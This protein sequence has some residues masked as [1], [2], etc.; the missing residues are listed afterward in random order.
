LEISAPHSSYQWPQQWTPAQRQDAFLQ[1]PI[2][3]QPQLGTTNAT[4][5]SINNSK[6]I[7]YVHH[8][9][10]FHQD[11]VQRFQPVQATFTSEFLW[12]QC[13]KWAAALG[14]TNLPILDPHASRTPLYT[15]NV[16]AA[17]QWSSRTEPRPP[18][19]PKPLAEITTK[20]IYLSVVTTQGT[21]AMLPGIW[22]LRPSTVLP[23]GD[24]WNQAR[25]RI[26]TSRLPPALLESRW[27]FLMGQIPSNAIRH[28]WDQAT[29]PKCPRCGDPIETPEHLICECPWAQD[30]WNLG[31]HILQQWIGAPNHPISKLEGIWSIKPLASQHLGREV[32]VAFIG[33]TIWRTRW[34]TTN[35]APSPP[36]LTHR[37]SL[38][39]NLGSQMEDIAST[40]LRIK[41]RLQIQA[42]PLI[43]AHGKTT[44]LPIRILHQAANM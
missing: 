12:D 26:T 30:L 40:K 25:I 37:I 22:K 33:L 44:T 2:W 5:E 9:L 7:Q 29:D 19:H 17:L 27:R 13:S 23:Q 16:G 20:Q 32:T 14:T 21:P 1:L 6:S 11:A 24:E 36:N 39:T 28:G 3:N 43:D 18:Q 15:V 42:C 35:D 34:L 38:L 31:N 4:P 8:L 41:H 10:S